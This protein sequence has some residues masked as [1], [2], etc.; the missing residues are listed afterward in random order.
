MPLNPDEAWRQLRDHADQDAY[1]HADRRARRL[2]GP[3]RDI[4]RSLLRLARPGTTRPPKGTRA[5]VGAWL[6]DAS[7]RRRRQ[8]LQAIHPQLGELL[9]AA[10]PAMVG[11][12]YTTDGHRRPFRAPH[13][14]DLTRTVRTRR[15]AD[16][17]GIVLDHDE[18]IS[19]FATWLGHLP[20]WDP[21]AVLGRFLGV[22]LAGGDVQVREVR[23]VLHATAAGDHPIGLISRGNLVALLNSPDAVDHDLV[24]SLLRAAQ[25]QEGLRSVILESVDL[26]AP[27]AYRRMLDVVR[28]DGLTRFASVARAAG[29][30]FGASFDVRDR[31]LIDDVL[32]ATSTF[33]QDPAA[34]AAALRGDD[35]RHVQLALWAHAFEDAPAT[36]PLAA[37]LL[38]ANDADVRRAA[39]HV[40]TDTQLHAAAVALLPHLGGPDRRVVPLAYLAAHRAHRRLTLE[41]LDAPVRSLLADVARPVQVDVGVLRPEE[42]TLDPRKVAGLLTAIATV[43]DVGRIDDLVDRLDAD[44]RAAYVQLLAKAPDLHRARLLDRLGDRSRSV[45][46]AAFEALRK[47]RPLDRDE[48]ERVEALFRRKA[49]TLRRGAVRLL[50]RQASSDAVVASVRRLLDGDELQRAGAVEVLLEFLRRDGTATGAGRRS[51]QDGAGGRARDLALELVADPGVPQPDRDR[52]AAVLGVD[53]VAPGVRSGA[54]AVPPPP[55]PAPAV[56]G[57]D[58]IPPPPPAPAGGDPPPVPAL[59]DPAARTPP[60]PVTPVPL[61]PE[62]W[63]GD[64]ERV[65]TS[66][67]AWLTEHRDVE[68][69]TLGHTGRETV[70]VSDLTF[71]PP[72]QG[73]PWPRPAQDVP[74]HELLDPWWERTRGQL[75]DE[76]IAVV[77]AWI[78]LE[79]H[80]HHALLNSWPGAPAPPGWERPITAALV[81]ADVV[82]GVT[83]RQ[84]IGA[85]LPWQAVQAAT[86]AWLPDLLDLTEAAIAAVP[87]R[88]RVARISLA[89]ARASYDR[90]DWRERAAT[91][92]LAV[93]NDL[94]LLR[95]ELF[96]PATRGRLWRLV[97]YVDEP[98]GSSDRDAGGGHLPTRRRSGGGGDEGDDRGRG[99]STAAGRTKDDRAR[100]RRF[101]PLA[102]TVRA[103]EDGTATRADLVDL[104]LS[105]RDWHSHTTRCA[106]TNVWEA[107]LGDLTRRRRHPL[108]DAH[109]WVAGVVAEVRDALVAA[110]LVR[111]EEPSPTS[112]AASRLR[113]VPGA[114]TVLRLLAAL[115][116]RGFVR[117]WVGLSGASAA[118]SLSHLIRVTFPAPDDTPAAFA[119]AAREAGIAERRLLELAVFAPQWAP[120]VEHAVGWEGLTQAVHWVHA[121]TKGDNWYVDEDVRAE[122]AAVAAEHTPLTADELVRGE[123]DVPWFERTVAR[124]GPQRFDQVLKVAK[125]AS[126]GGG[127]KRAELFAKAIRGD[128]DRVALE[129][130]IEEKRHQDSVRA[131][132]LL[133]LPD[134]GEGRAAEVLARYGRLQDWKRGSAAFGA[135]RRASEAAAVEVGLANLARTAGYPDPQR[136][137]WAMEAE[138]VR[139]LA[140][141]PVVVVEGDVTVSLAL[142]ADGAPAL[143]IRRG[144]RALKGVPKAVANLPAVIALK[145][146][147][148]E[149]RAQTRRMRASLEAGMVRG[150]TF[151][152]GEVAALLAHPSLAP[153][154]RRLVFVA[155]PAGLA[156]ERVVEVGRG[157]GGAAGAGNGGSGGAAGDG[158]GLLGADATTLV[159]TD[160]S[161]VAVGERHLRI[162]HPTDLLASGGWDRW[163][164]RLFVEEVRQPCK[165]VFRELYV[166][167]AAERDGVTRSD[168]Y[169]G[170]QLEARRAAALFGTRGWVLDREVGAVRTFHTE[171]V[172]VRVELLQGF[173]TAAEAADAMLGSVAF[174][175]AATDR[176]L[177][178]DEVPPRLFSEVMR[179]VDLVVSVAH[180]GGVDPEASTST[181]E[182]RG[183]LVQETAELLGFDNVEL[184]DHHALITGTL[185]TYSV[186]LGS[187]TVH[188]RPGNAVCIIP[189]G[190]QHRGRL[191]L[192]FVD[193]DPRTAEVVSKVVLLARDERIKDPTILSQLR[194]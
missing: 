4:A 111:G 121:H 115:G 142:D 170:H 178:I 153:M 1:Q 20:I 80:Q 44:G 154:L 86:S 23:E 187:G 116:R 102:M 179:D 33:L 12:P 162:A 36:V 29:V 54:G 18:P 77:L 150:D 69:T 84:L 15:L 101:A 99:G 185:G 167:T 149:L 177:A 83:Y 92:P 169:A 47:G 68:V 193:D 192:P 159:G 53:A 41:Q 52:L 128:L 89:A 66:L 126:G 5:K 135:Q 13:D 172:T 174:F 118:D 57:G 88:V 138:A 8:V 106:V 32:A 181:V 133:P 122:W 61:D 168:R 148:T 176:L 17:V 2:I 48:A 35:A 110:E 31:P 163:Q 62:R 152:P 49:A 188:R 25:R 131:L 37:E 11:D 40:L 76:G 124:L 182:M 123:V 132:G 45:Q 130:R 139:D 143:T 50:V 127:H 136:L 158:L 63:R 22:A 175:H 16:L 165:Q 9:A 125:L 189:V 51:S 155:E 119:A 160:G 78:A 184:T 90:A 190:A 85:L 38:D 157:A 186:H 96:D 65:L 21:D 156:G 147:V 137:T 87:E 161:A 120:F 166:P 104:L 39:A 109:P 107:P 134:D 7:E 46:D 91:G 28:E 64:V 114:D 108:L 94:E 3:K 58:A 144:E 98:V 10:W 103:I 95:P 105:E 24:V 194:T 19:W 146:R 30:W 145:A 72:P 93:V 141:G 171:G 117:G 73:G 42:V 6:D 56:N 140:A 79:L 43:D 191:F 27:T 129:T 74:L 97:R 34:R 82:D 183:A 151:T 70:L 75:A 14:P 71:L 173:L 26:A 112:E 67:D 113:S 164:H 59:H 81:P 100:R 180:S 55:P 60:V